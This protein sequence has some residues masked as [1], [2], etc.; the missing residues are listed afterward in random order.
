MPAFGE[1]QAFAVHVQDSVPQVRANRRRNRS[2]LE[3]TMVFRTAGDSA[4]R[5]RAENASGIR[6]SVTGPKPGEVDSAFEATA[7]GR[8]SYNLRTSVTITHHDVNLALDARRP[9]PFVRF[10]S[11]GPITEEDLG[12]SPGEIPPPYPVSETSTH[13]KVKKPRPVSAPAPSAEVVKAMLDAPPTKPYIPA[14]PTAALR[15]ITSPLQ[16]QYDADSDSAVES[17]LSS[18][19]PVLNFRPH[20]FGGGRS[21]DPRRLV[22][23]DPLPSLCPR[24]PSDSSFVEDY[25]PEGV[26]EREHPVTESQNTLEVSTSSEC[27][28]DCPAAGEKEGQ[29][30]ISQPESNLAP[31]PSFESFANDSSVENSAESAVSFTDSIR[32]RV[33]DIPQRPSKVISLT[34]A[35]KLKLYGS[36]QISS[37]SSLPFG[38]PS[39]SPP[40][41]F[42]R[43]ER[44]LG[45]AVGSSASL[46]SRVSLKNTN[47]V[48]TSSNGKGMKALLGKAMGIRKGMKRSREDEENVD[49]ENIQDNN[50]RPIAG[51]RTKR[52]LMGMSGGQ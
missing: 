33:T 36:R 5:V 16:A 10:V 40:S 20:Q 44:A 2:V 17:P 30:T 1:N 39:M 28:D 34:E 6:I 14:R 26:Q 27:L 31:S 38:R 25:S 51:R 43:F 52:K 37:S 3:T 8:S 13:E 29:G 18:P 49:P 7:Y 23:N 21:V 9:R 4:T 19:S 32:S 35:V 12:L 50:D 11:V 15:V 48:G 47:E 22:L 45:A 46:N 42:Q 41:A 24:S